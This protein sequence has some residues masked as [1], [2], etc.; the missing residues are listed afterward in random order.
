MSLQSLVAELDGARVGLLM[1]ADEDWH[2]PAEQKRVC[3]FV[4]AMEKSVT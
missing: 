3:K 2:T 4:E 1:V